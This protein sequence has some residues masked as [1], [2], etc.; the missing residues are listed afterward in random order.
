MAVSV[1]GG[2][3]MRMGGHRLNSGIVCFLPECAKCRIVYEV[4]EHFH[5]SST[6]ARA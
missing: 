1:S 5:I 4:L 2:V 3:K 6:G